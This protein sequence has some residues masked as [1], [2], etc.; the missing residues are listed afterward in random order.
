MGFFAKLFSYK[1]SCIRLE[2]EKV[3]EISSPKYIP[4]FIRNL[5]IIMPQGSILYLEGNPSRKIKAELNNF[6]IKP[7]VKV[8]RAT[9]LPAPICFHIPMTPENLDSIRYLFKK[10]VHASIC[11]HFHVYASRNVLL[12]WHDAFFDDPFLISETIQE[13]KIKLFCDEV[14]C[15]YKKIDW[16]Y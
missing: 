10:N 7:T 13:D 15:K 14:G 6:K 1:P 3:W 4:K 2:G 5:A 8:A 16:P 11:Y 9:L 12:E